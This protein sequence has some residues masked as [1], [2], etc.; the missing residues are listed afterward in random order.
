MLRAAAAT[1]GPRGGKPEENC[2]HAEHS[3]AQRGRELALHVD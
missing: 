3:R 2:Q 1:L